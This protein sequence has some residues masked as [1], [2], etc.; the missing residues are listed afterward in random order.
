MRF[1]SCT[2]PSASHSPSLMLARLPLIPADG[3]FELIMQEVVPIFFEVQGHVMTSK[4]LCLC[5]L[6]CVVCR[7]QS[8]RVR[9]GSSEFGFVPN[10]AGVDPLP[11]SPACSARENER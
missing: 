3:E 4:F 8:L 10:D 9:S 6:P 11:L 1:L 2:L 7:T 5:P